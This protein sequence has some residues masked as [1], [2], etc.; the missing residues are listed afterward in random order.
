MITLRKMRWAGYMTLKRKWKANRIL[1]GKTEGTKPLERPK[2]RREDNIEMDFREI[3]QVRLDW[4]Y[5]A[6]S[7]LGPVEC[8]YE[9]GI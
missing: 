3:G 1:L 2:Q 8:S 5:V 7:V 4:I 9:H 6:Q